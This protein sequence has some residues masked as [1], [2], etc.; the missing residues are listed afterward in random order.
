MPVTDDDIRHITESV[1]LA[2]LGL[3]VDDNPVSFGDGP[4]LTG[5]VVISGAWDGAVT[6]EVSDGLARAAA[7]TMFDVAEDELDGEMVRDALGEL[8]NMTGGNIKTL[9]EGVCALSIPSVTEGR[10]YSLSLPG[11]TVVNAV[12]LACGGQPL[13]VTVL[14]RQAGSP[15]CRHP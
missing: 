6:V 7:A 14:E 15:T 2:T 3:P 8:A 11:T 1:W 9:V 12:K 5:L 13:V 4:R 10:E